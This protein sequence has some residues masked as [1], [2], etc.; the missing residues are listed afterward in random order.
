MQRTIRTGLWM[1]GAGVAFLFLTQMLAQYGN[2]GP[3]AGR[4]GSFTPALLPAPL[5]PAAYRHL[6]DSLAVELRPRTDA[7]DSVFVADVT[8]TNRSGSAVSNV[9]LSCDA[10]G[11]S[12]ETT[13]RATAVLHQSFAAHDTTTAPNVALRFVHRPTTARCAIADF[14]IG[15]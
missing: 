13:A 10:V 3:V 1:I 5:A 11:E 4:R 2:G 15:R 9:T 14:T 12:G 7:F 8:I 6:A